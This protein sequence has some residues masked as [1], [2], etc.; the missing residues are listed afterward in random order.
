VF[1]ACLSY[2]AGPVTWMGVV[3]AGH[4]FRGSVPATHP[5]SNYEYVSA[6]GGTPSVRPR[7]V[8]A[9]NSESAA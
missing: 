2:C 4:V 8:K 9:S 1:N 3:V 5:L 7:H 6:P